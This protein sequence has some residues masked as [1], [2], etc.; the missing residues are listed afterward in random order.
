MT[1]TMMSRLLPLVLRRGKK[2]QRMTKKIM[3]KEKGG[4]TKEEKCIG[5]ILMLR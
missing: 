2:Q 3:K 5:K 4:E 1:K